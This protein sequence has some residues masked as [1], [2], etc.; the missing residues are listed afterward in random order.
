[1]VYTIGQRISTRSEN[2]IAFL[3]KFAVSPGHA[4][5]LPSGMWSIIFLLSPAEQ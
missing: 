3:D 1:M 5:V 4:L 2:A